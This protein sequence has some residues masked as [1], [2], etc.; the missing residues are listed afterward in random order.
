MR[1]MITKLRHPSSLSRKAIIVEDFLRPVRRS[2]LTVEALV[3]H[4]GT[5]WEWLKCR[6]TD[7]KQRR[8]AQVAPPCMVLAAERQR[9]NKPITRQPSRNTR[10]VILWLRVVGL[11]PPNRP[12][13][14]ACDR[15]SSGE[16]QDRSFSLREEVA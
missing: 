13:G 16:S 2:L 3:S 4:A 6:I 9:T 12:I 8:I 15:M 10:I 7:D 11:E 5:M 14:F 1:I